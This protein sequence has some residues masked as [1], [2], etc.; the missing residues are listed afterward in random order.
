MSQTA[1]YGLHLSEDSSE[2][3]M[4]WRQKMNGAGDSN[5]KII[6][7][8]LG[9]KADS[10]MVFTTTL[11][12]MSWEQQATPL[13][14]AISDDDSLPEDPLPSEG[15]NEGGKPGDD[16][17]DIGGTDSDP[18]YHYNKISVTGLTAEKNGIIC[19]S[20]TATKEQRDA[21]KSAELFV[22]KQE[23]SYLYIGVDGKIPTIDIPVSVVLF[24]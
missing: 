11:S 21:A 4:S 2:T 10:S 24:G 20:P 12:A 17:T 14:L 5:M 3:F 18:S 19:V 1:N 22:R 15:G 9:S 7:T 16:V 8:I 6:D 23:D 13:A